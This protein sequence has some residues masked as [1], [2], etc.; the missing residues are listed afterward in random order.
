MSVKFRVKIE[1]EFVVFR[2]LF[3]RSAEIETVDLSRS[4]VQSKSIDE[5]NRL[6]L[7]YRSQQIVARNLI[8]LLSETIFI[9]NFNN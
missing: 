9:T 7:P 3:P 5:V 6:T 4:K 2:R 1:E 8:C